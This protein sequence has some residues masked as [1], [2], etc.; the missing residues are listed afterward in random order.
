MTS[1]GITTPESNTK[2]YTDAAYKQAVFL[3]SGGTLSRLPA[4]LVEA[5]LADFPDAVSQGHGVYTVN[6]SQATQAG[7]LDFGFGSTIIHVPFNEFIWEPE[8][9]TCVFGAVA[10]AEND[11]D[12]VLGGECPT[13]V[14]SFHPRVLFTDAPVDTFLRAAYV[15]Y[16]QDNRNLLLANSANCGTNVVAI[17]SG[18]D[19]VPSIT[20][21]CT[22]AATPSSKAAASSTLVTTAATATVTPA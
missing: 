4:N 17:T 22:A 12:W 7:S 5:M 19:A 8:P 13:L 20:G 18:I 14:S 10:N 6:C 9:G 15:V 11:V 21:A 1:V 16:D 2:T 3:D